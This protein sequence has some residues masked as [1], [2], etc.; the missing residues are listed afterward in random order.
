MNRKIITLFTA[1]LFVV[2]LSFGQDNLPTAK[3]RSNSFGKEVDFASIAAQ[4]KDTVLLVSFWAT[5]CV[6]C[7]NELDNINDVYKEKQA[8]KP[9]KLIAVSIDDSRTSQRVKP[10]VT[11]KGWQFD[12]YIDVNSELKRAFN[13]TD[14][15]C[16]MLIKNNKVVYQH[17]G[18]VAG[19]EEDLFDKIKSL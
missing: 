17:T 9:F 2:A 18:Y 10:F 13:V 1:S 12:V 5:W 11:G 8:V 6:P 7:V 3:I 4:S 16:V 19:S 15:P 14:V